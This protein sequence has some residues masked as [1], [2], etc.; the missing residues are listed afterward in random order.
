MKLLRT[1][2][3]MLWF[4]IYVNCVFCFSLQFPSSFYSKTKTGVQQY[5]DYIKHCQRTW[6]WTKEKR[7]KFMMI[8]CFPF[9]CCE[10]RR[11]GEKLFWLHSLSEKITLAKSQSFWSSL[12]DNSRDKDLSFA[13]H[14][15]SFSFLCRHKEQ[16]NINEW[17]KNTQKTAATEMK[18]FCLLCRFKTVL[19]SAHRGDIKYGWMVLSENREA[20][21]RLETA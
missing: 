20:K 15:T 17:K 18:R 16:H 21:K 12:N 10:P 19:L 5:S 9:V 13:F 11:G 1:E 3:F 6:T 2:E 7:F 4:E 8:L 14:E